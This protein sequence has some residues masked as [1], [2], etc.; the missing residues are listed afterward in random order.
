MLKPATLYLFLAA[1][2]FSVNI[3]YEKPIVG[4]DFILVLARR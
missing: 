3:L 2:Q 4:I 1:R